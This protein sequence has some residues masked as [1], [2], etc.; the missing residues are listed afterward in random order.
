[1]E[2]RRQFVRLPTTA[3]VNYQLVSDASSSDAS[4]TK[5]ISGG[6]IRLVFNEEIPNGALLDLTVELPDQTPPIPCKGMVVWVEKITDQ[7]PNLWEVGVEFT[8]IS[9]LDRD[10]ILEFVYKG[11]SRLKTS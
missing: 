5:D 8:D 3:R 2:E 4:G 11:R 9:V 10:A 1:M 6:G 7:E